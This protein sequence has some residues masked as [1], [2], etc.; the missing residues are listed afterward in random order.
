VTVQATVLRV[1]PILKKTTKVPQK[2][3]LKG[4]QF[5]QLSLFRCSL[6]IKTYIFH[7]DYTLET[8]IGLDFLPT[9]NE[10]CQM[11]TLRVITTK[12]N[13][14]VEKSNISMSFVI[15]NIAEQFRVRHMSVCKS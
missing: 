13:E 10:D 1:E 7:C 2:Y 12:T 8:S 9:C 6:A 3:I 4:H 11:N 14:M 15:T 5:L